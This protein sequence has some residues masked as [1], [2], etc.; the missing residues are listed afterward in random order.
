MTAEAVLV[1]PAFGRFETLNPWSLTSGALIF[2]QV[3]WFSSVF[4]LCLERQDTAFCRILLEKRPLPVQTANAE[5]L[6]N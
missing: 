6:F 2:C 5:G 1:L 3:Y 4:L